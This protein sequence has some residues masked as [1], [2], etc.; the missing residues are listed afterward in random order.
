MK[1]IIIQTSPFLIA[2]IVFLIIKIIAE[3]KKRTDWK[4]WATPQEKRLRKEW[5]AE[6]A[7]EEHTESA[8]KQRTRLMTQAEFEKWKAKQKKKNQGGYLDLDAIAA[9][10]RR[11]AA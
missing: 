9:L 11:K 5:E 7:A 6:K 10:F 4:N 8:P 2:I 1:E 3:K